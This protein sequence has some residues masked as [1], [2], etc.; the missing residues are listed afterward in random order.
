MAV[1]ATKIQDCN[2]IIDAFERGAHHTN[3][4]AAVFAPIT[5]SVQNTKTFAQNAK[6]I[7]KGYQ[8]TP[9]IGLAQQTADTP[10]ANSQTGIKIQNQYVTI[11][12]SK[13]TGTLSKILKE[14]IPCEFR[15][16]STLDVNI[17]SDLLDMLK[18]DYKTRLDILDKIGDLFSNVDVYGDFCEMASFLNFMCIPD[19]Q[20]ILS[21]LSALLGEVSINLTSL[22]GLLQQLIQPFFTPILFSMQVLLDKYTQLVLGPL[23]CIMVAIQ[24]QVR[25]VNIPALMSDTEA[26][27]VIQE[28]NVAGEKSALEIKAFQ[29]Q[30]RSGLVELYNKLNFGNTI[31]RKKLYF[32]TT[33]IEKLLHTWGIKDGQYMNQANQKIITLRLIGLVKAMIE[34]RSK[35]MKLCEVGNK[36]GRTE[37]DNFYGHFLSPTSPFTISVDANGNLRIDEKS[38]ELP[39]KNQKNIDKVKHIA[40]TDRLQIPKTLL[41]SLQPV[42]QIFKCKIT[43]TKDDVAKVN[44]WIK[45]LDGG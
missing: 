6:D 22:N 29:G 1:S 3:N 19:L 30:I 28:V 43:T 25:K 12:D 17:K 42:S 34:F 36:P 41:D 20:R 7:I 13:Q 10:D 37:M 8:I 40:S 44:N 45:Q 21:T 2:L 31:V 32:Y 27:K 4:E 39:K 24:E 14:C 23:E 18:A 33:Q 35:G 16:I 38:K 11:P 15:A 5:R 9:T 26:R